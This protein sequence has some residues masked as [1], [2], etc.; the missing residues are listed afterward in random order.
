MPRPHF[1]LV[2][3]PAQAHINPALQLAKQLASTSSAH[4]TFTTTATALRRINN[5]NN[6]HPFLTHATISDGYEEN[7]DNPASD[8]PIQRLTRFSLAGSKSLLVLARSLSDQGHPVTCIIYTLLLP[9]A[10]DV[11]RQ[12]G[13][14]SAV[15]WLQ[16]AAVFSVYYHYF[17]G[18][19]DV[20][21]SGV[22]QPEFMVNL[23]GL[24][25]LTSRDLPSF[26]LPNDPYSSVIPAFEEQF[27]TIIERQVG[28]MSKPKVLVNTFYALESDVVKSMDG[29][30]LIGVGPMVPLA[31]IKEHDS[32]SDKTFGVDLFD[33]DEKDYK[34]WLDAKPE[35]SVVYVSFGSIALLQKRQ[36]EEMTKGLMESGRPFL[37]VLRKAQREAE[38]DFVIGTEVIEDE[39]GMVVEWCS[40]VEVLSHPSIGCFVT[41]CG[42]NS[43]VESLFSGVPTV[44][45]PQWSDQP[46]NAKMVEDVWGS[47]FRG[48]VNGEGLVEAEELIRCLKAVLGEEGEGVR[49]RAEEWRDKALEAVREG[50]SSH[51]SLGR[52]V[53]EVSSHESE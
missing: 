51:R 45:M 12:L 53:E 8:S 20:I 6:P 28:D 1:L 13:I 3:Y 39:R 49:R 43:T 10:A 50:G 16:P 14:S 24:P 11:A 52:F 37:W 36:L 38:K 22:H 2:T 9:W 31:Y 35:K 19:K 27:K 46:T 47:G 41:H 33:G 29:V 26:F 21:D 23:P 30:E 7:G 25:P 4:I 48:R 42:W 44:G 15:F 40:Q 5:N 18:Y 17:N 32:S 34:K